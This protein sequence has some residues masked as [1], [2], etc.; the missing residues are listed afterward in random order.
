MRE[1]L[2]ESNTPMTVSV[3][4]GAPS[5][6]LSMEQK[7]VGPVRLRPTQLSQQLQQTVPTHIHWL[8]SPARG[9]G[10]PVSW[11]AWELQNDTPWSALNQREMGTAGPQTGKLLGVSFPGHH[12]P[13]VRRGA[14]HMLHSEG[15]CSLASFISPPPHSLIM[16]LLFSC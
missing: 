11:A 12:P 14:E 8:P 2:Q 13:E 6:L 15:S 4:L 16:L 5:S 7:Y 9:H 3:S 10:Q 1:G